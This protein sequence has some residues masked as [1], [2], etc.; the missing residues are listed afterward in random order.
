MPPRS[1]LSEPRVPAYTR[2]QA[3]LLLCVLS[4]LLDT[5]FAGTG[6]T[7]DECLTPDSTQH[8]TVFSSVRW[9]ERDVYPFLERV[10]PV[11]DTRV[12]RSPRLKRGTVHTATDA[13][14]NGSHY[15]AHGPT[16]REGGDWRGTI[17]T[18]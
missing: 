1:S 6:P 9:K 8:L 5:G 2:V 11:R 3:S 14:L 18:P 4:C 16:F 13:V 17:V 10:A 15:S 12:L 7:P